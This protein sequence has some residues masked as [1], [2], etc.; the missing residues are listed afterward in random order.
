[1][2]IEIQRKNKKF[3]RI[4][5]LKRLYVFVEPTQIINTSH[6]KLSTAFL[7]YMKNINIFHI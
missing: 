7:I 6:K 2:I 3:L 4:F 1:M 5:S